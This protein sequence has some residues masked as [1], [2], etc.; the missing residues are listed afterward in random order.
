MQKTKNND[1]VLEAAQVLRAGKSFQDKIQRMTRRDRL[2]GLEAAYMPVL[3]DT[4]STGGDLQQWQMKYG[5]WQQGAT[6]LK[7]GK[8]PG[9]Y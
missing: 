8:Q 9:T 4:G 3:D 5:S 1:Q 6:P 2:G 7:N